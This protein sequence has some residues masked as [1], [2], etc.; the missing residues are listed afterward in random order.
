MNETFCNVTYLIVGIAATALAATGLFQ[1][2]HQLLVDTH[3]GDTKGVRHFIRLVVAGFSLIMVGYLAVTSSFAA[4][5]V[6]PGDLIRVES[7]LV[8]FLLLVMGITLL[9]AIFVLG[10]LRHRRQIEV[11]PPPSIAA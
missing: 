6:N 2:S 9:L 1:G 7:T 8:G 4:S 3:Q 11:N 10:T 5:G